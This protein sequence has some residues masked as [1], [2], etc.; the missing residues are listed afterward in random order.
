VSASVERSTADRNRRPW[1]DCSA[2]SETSNISTVAAVRHE[3][4]IVTFGH[5]NPEK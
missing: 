3:A 1:L 2:Q 5:V 4:V